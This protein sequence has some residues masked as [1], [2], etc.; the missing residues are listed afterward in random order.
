MA[1]INA[2]QAISRAAGPAKRLLPFV[3]AALVGSFA[4][5]QID[6]S[7]NGPGNCQQLRR[8]IVAAESMV[9]WPNGQ[10]ET[11]P[12]DSPYLTTPGIT[13]PE[14][15]SHSDAITLPYEQCEFYGSLWDR[16]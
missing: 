3:A 14:I 9:R 13:K 15:L 5:A 1:L 12:D 11:L 4:G 2:R 10:I 16:P 8:A 7:V 6:H